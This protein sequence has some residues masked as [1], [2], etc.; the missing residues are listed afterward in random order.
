ML[1]HGVDIGERDR[2]LVADRFVGRRIVFVDVALFEVEEAVAE[3]RVGKGKECAA[4]SERRHEE[5]AARHDV[6]L[7]RWLVLWWKARF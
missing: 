7:W 3:I 2:R 1:E 6:E 5:L 4:V